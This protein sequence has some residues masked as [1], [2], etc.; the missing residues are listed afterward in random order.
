M[1]MLPE[2]SGY[3]H[4]WW[5][6]E[7][8]VPCQLSFP[9]PISCLLGSSQQAPL[10]LYFFSLSGLWYQP[11]YLIFPSL[12]PLYTMTTQN[13]PGQ[14]LRCVTPQC[15]CLVSLLFP[16]A[17]QRPTCTF[18]GKGIFSV[19]V[20]E[21]QSCPNLTR[22][23]CASLTS[24]TP[25]FL[26]VSLPSSP[27]QW[28]PYL[29]AFRVAFLL[30]FGQTV[31]SFS[32]GLGLRTTDPANFFLMSPSHFSLSRQLPFVICADLPQLCNLL[33]GYQSL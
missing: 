21:S 4:L 6:A 10:N 9:H 20:K 7:V 27:G 18:L 26:Q 24:S 33:G 30:L 3:S 8:L 16:E 1:G 12:C 28:V 11:P 31:D 29:L 17:I 5:T 13:V 23:Y 19:K 14:S 2:I 15:T 25:F 32:L 22:V